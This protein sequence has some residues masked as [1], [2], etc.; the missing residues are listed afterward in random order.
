MWRDDLKTVDA[1]AKRVEEVSE[2]LKRVSPEQ[3]AAM[4]AIPW[5]A[6]KGMG[7]VLAH[8]YGMLDLDLLAEIVDVELPRLIREIEAGLG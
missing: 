2:N 4:P 8:D 1:A 6:A 5:K 3:Q 7:E